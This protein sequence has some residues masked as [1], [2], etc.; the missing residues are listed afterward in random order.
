MSSGPSDGKSASV[1]ADCDWRRKL[2]I[3]S[4]FCHQMVGF[5]KIPRQT[6]ESFPYRHL[7]SLIPPC[8]GLQRRE[9]RRI[10]KVL[11]FTFFEFHFRCPMMTRDWSSIVFSL[12]PLLSPAPSSISPTTV[13]YSTPSAI[14]PAHAH[15]TS[16]AANA[17]AAPHDCCCLVLD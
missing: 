5:W 16:A 4:C 2:R 15:P 12:L 14:S 17:E 6:S 7:L 8:F 13:T 3:Y 11:V 1:R 9:A 10:V